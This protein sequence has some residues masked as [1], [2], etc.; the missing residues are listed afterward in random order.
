MKRHNY[1]F[2]QKV[3]EA[4]LDQG[5][6]YAEDADHKIV[7]DIGMVGIN[8]GFGVAEHS[9][10]LNLT[11]DVDGPGCAYD[12]TGQRISFAALQNCD[13]SQDSGGSPTAVVTPGNTKW[14]SVFIKFK[15]VDSDPRTDGYGGTVYFTRDES[16]EFVVRQGAEGNPTPAPPSLESDAI[17]LADILMYHGMTQVVDADIYE[18][19]RQAAVVVEMTGTYAT[20]LLAG[21][22][23]EAASLLGGMLDAHF[24]GTGYRHIAAGMDYAGGP[25]WLDGT[26]NPA[27]T[28]E[29]QLDKIIS[30][31]ATQGTGASG[32]SKAGAPALAGSPDSL[33][34]GS[35]ESQL[36]E[37][38]G[39]VNAR[40]P[41]AGGTMTGDILLDTGSFGSSLGRPNTLQDRWYAYLASVDAKSGDQYEPAVRG[42]AYDAD[43]W[44]A[45]FQGKGAGESKGLLLKH[46]D[47]G[48]DYWDLLECSRVRVRSNVIDPA[49]SADL[50]CLSKRCLPVAWGSITS[51]GM[52][53]VHYNVGSV[54]H[55]GT[56]RYEVTYDV[57]ISSAGQGSVVL[58]TPYYGFE[59]AQDYSIHVSHK[60]HTGC[61]FMIA[62][63]GVAEDV[64][65]SFVVFSP[66]TGI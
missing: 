63:A 5:F 1:Y 42:E 51:G 36:A 61:R 3:T 46:I 65:F 14:V 34:V 31:L 40:L 41:L 58:A 12:A 24:S 66:F 39:L 4:E 25:N 38:L 10:T 11:V 15:R 18:T 23:S 33:A 21:K 52:A 57:A 49:A 32:A 9:P 54:S 56:G 29:A 60:T 55:P 6:D 13:V 59:L 53:T 37:L 35:V 2:R 17:L 28:V 8:Y 47:L 19:R 26:T 30:D 50:Y 62:N 7:S 20:R 27:A 48:T 64:D 43:T 22:V 45:Y 16:W 44:A